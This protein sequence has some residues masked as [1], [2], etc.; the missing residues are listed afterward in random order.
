MQ[1]MFRTLSLVCSS[2]LL[3]VAIGCG[4]EEGDGDVGDWIVEPEGATLPDG[5]T[6][7]LKQMDKKQVELAL[8]ATR[9]E[10]NKARTSGFQALMTSL[11]SE[12]KAKG[13]DTTELEKLD[14]KIVGTADDSDAKEPSTPPK[15]S[16]STTSAGGYGSA[17]FAVKKSNYTKHYAC[18]ILASEKG[19][20]NPCD[21]LVT[22]VLSK[23]KDQINKN[24]AAVEATIKTTYKDLDTKAQNF[25]AAWAF[26]A[27]QYGASVAATYAEHELKAAAK[28]DDKSNANEISYHLGVE[29]GWAIVLSMKA[30]AL[31]QVTSCVTNTDA[32]AQSVLVKAK[33]KIDAY[34]KA[35]KVCENTD[36]SN[37]ND[38]LQ[39]AEIKRKSGI[40]VG[41][42]QRVQILRN[43]LFQRRQN[44]PCPNSGGGGDPIVIDL[45]GDGL[46]LT[47]DRVAFDM[48]GDGT[49]QQSTWTRE[50]FLAL[51]RNGNGLVDSVSELMGNQSQCGDHLCYDGVSSLNALDGNKDG[52]LN[53]KDRIFSKLL[54][55]VD[56]NLDG[57]SQPTEVYSLDQKGIRS[58]NLT[59]TDISVRNEGGFVSAKLSLETDN[60]PRT[61]YDVWFNVELSTKNL[62]ALGPR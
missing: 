44:T 10:I 22:G 45:E 56:A 13:Y 39:K 62:P 60:G 31:S 49:K 53:S 43:E 1:T 23:V 33:A 52:V 29:Q 20:G 47:S 5:Q 26:T 18:P 11:V 32:I 3:F 28:C 59:R 40:K 51:D 8:K 54:V 30:W 24:K 46:T 57:G 25:I 42:D 15:E 36:I 21:K 6:Q 19:T 16:S 27:N 37:L 7:P 41:I 48:L 35:N 2:L 61:A 58:I 12:L 55:W 34:M 9:V 4:G 38:A 14:V 17:T 50:G